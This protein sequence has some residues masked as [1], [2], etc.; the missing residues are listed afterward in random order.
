MR[1]HLRTDISLCCDNVKKYCPRAFQCYRATAEPDELGQSYFAP[2][3]PGDGCKYF[4]FDTR[5]G[6]Q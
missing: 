3:N 2:D 5:K 4:I 1:G 6:G